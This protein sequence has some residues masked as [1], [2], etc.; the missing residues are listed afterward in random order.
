[1]PA[2]GVGVACIYIGDCNPQNNPYLR[3]ERVPWKKKNENW[4]KWW[5]GNIAFRFETNGL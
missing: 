2:K 1:M 3:S 5:E 4:D